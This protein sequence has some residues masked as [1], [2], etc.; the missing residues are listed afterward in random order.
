M[1]IEEAYGRILRLKRR[2]ML[3]DLEGKW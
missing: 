1:R 2:L 3:H